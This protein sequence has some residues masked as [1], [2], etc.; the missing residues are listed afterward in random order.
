[1]D[2][3]TWEKLMERCMEFQKA[4]HVGIWGY[5]IITSPLLVDQKQ[6]LVKR[7]WKE[8]W[9]ELPFRPWQKTKV[10]IYYVPKKEYYILEKQKTIVCHPE[11]ARQLKEAIYNMNNE[12]SC[13]LSSFTTNPLAYTVIKNVLS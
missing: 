8:R 10:E 7:S 2:N 4:G 3:L 11:M 1:M 13:N 6:E 5:Q 12:W 9:F